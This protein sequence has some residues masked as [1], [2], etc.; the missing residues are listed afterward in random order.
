MLGILRSGK[1][2]FLEIQMQPIWLINRSNLA[3][4]KRHSGIVLC[5][6]E[7]TLAIMQLFRLSKTFLVTVNVESADECRYN[8]FVLVQNLFKIIHDCGAFDR[9]RFFY[10]RVLSS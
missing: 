3:L 4:E 8:R 5:Q 2:T 10:P 9:A 1:I 6:N 7:S